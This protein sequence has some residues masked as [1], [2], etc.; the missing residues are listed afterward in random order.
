MNTKSMVAGMAIGSLLVIGIQATQSVRAESGAAPTGQTRE[1]SAR[2]EDCHMSMASMMWMMHQHHAMMGD[3]P[4]GM[5]GDGMMGAS[6]DGMMGDG[7]MGAS[8]DGMMGASPEPEAT[9]APPSTGPGDQTPA[10]DAS[11]VAGHEEHHP[12]PSPVA[13]PGQS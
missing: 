11:S 1:M 3:W 5:M 4:D 8:P 12:S 7:M 9:T 13:S 10:P 2:H 6:P